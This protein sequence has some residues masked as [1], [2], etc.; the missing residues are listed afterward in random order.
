VA[1]V[2]NSI[3]NLAMA[4]VWGSMQYKG[5][6]DSTLR[7][8][9]DSVMEKVSSS[10]YAHG[11]FFPNLPKTL[12]DS[13]GTDEPGI[14]QVFQPAFNPFDPLDVGV[15]TGL[16]TMLRRVLLEGDAERYEQLFSFAEVRRLEHHS[17]L[18]FETAA[19]IGGAIVLPAVLYYGC[20]KAVYF[21]RRSGAETGI[22]ETE[23]ELKKEEL[24]QSQI[25]TQ[26]QQHLAAAILET[27]FTTG[28]INVPDAV[29]A[30]TARI[31]ATTVA[32]LGACPRNRFF[33]AL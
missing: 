8:A 22:R 23:H 28:P 30:E 4:C 18:L 11:R 27:K 10:P 17:P 15:Q 16:N 5:L 14:P 25:R 2:V 26:V 32:D 29:M 12:F 21:A 6:D 20:M 24:R 9:R 3:D 13:V 19:I 7:W 33:L 1:W 31:A